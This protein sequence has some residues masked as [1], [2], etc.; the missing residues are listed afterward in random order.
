MK[1]LSH[2]KMRLIF[3]KLMKYIGNNIKSFIERPDGPYHFR[4]KK[5]RVYYVSQKILSIANNIE[6]DN[7][8]SLGTCIGRFTKSGK[9]RLHI[10]ALHHIAP[11]AQ[12]KIWVKPSAEQQFLYGNNIMKSGLARITEGINQYQGV[13]VFSM[14]D[15]PL[16]FGVAAKNTADCKHADP[17]AI[18][19]FHEADIGDY[20]RSED[21]LL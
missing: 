2:A 15:L 12:H 19:C 14:N 6:S 11:Y 16:G 3:Q 8:L 17:V 10:T 21:T 13:V 20:I 18:I 7:L 9:F 1:N 4:E 5:D